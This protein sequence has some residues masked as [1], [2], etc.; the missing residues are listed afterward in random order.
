MKIAKVKAC[1]R[2]GVLYMV[3]DL[4][5]DALC[6]RPNVFFHQFPKFLITLLLALSN[7]EPAFMG[8]KNW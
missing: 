5:F 4:S 8:T 2:N 7:F 3:N 1:L 6:V